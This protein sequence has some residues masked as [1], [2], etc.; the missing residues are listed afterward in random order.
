MRF[1]AALL[2]IFVITLGGGALAGPKDYDGLWGGTYSCA[3]WNRPGTFTT[4]VSNGSFVNRVG[5]G[6]TGKIEGT[7]GP[8]GSA[9]VT[10][11]ISGSGNLNAT[12]TGRATATQLIATGNDTG[13]GRGFGNCT[14]RMVQAS[15]DPESLQGKAL[16]AERASRPPGY[17]DAAERSL[18]QLTSP[19]GTGLSE[20]TA[21]EAA[22][23]AVV[24]ASPPA[25]TLP[26]AAAPPV[27]APAV[28]ALP[29]APSAPTQAPTSPIAQ[30]ACVLQPP[31]RPAR[32]AAGLNNK[33]KLYVL[34]VG[35]SRYAESSLNLDFAA[36]DACDLARSL[37]GQQDGLYRQVELRMI[38]NEAANRE[39]ILD[40][41]DWIVKETTARD[42]AMVFL[43]GHGVND[44]AG[45]YFFLP[46]DANLDRLARSAL[47]QSDIRRSLLQV[48]GKALFFFDT[49]HSGQI[50]AG[51]RAVPP[52]VGRFAAALSAA[53]NS[54]I[55]FSAATGR[56][57][58]IEDARWGNGA[59][60]KAL[61]E[62]IAGRADYQKDDVI[63]LNE[64]ELY[65]SE[66]VKEL[67]G[68][69]QAPTTAKPS[70]TQDFPIAVVR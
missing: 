67:T 49:C 2:S 15:A 52:D 19:Y 41:L 66:R 26:P 22:P 23:P 62:G 24:A 68:G 55:V 9:R 58:A 14:L 56:Q 28:A 43:A 1:Y 8:E 12:F 16:A 31:S 6:S 46:H 57:F 51:R 40:G 50:M 18:R 4:S 44:A 64:L 17:L 32:P 45:E 27:V 36:K 21:S 34:S 38:Q 37:S 60:T 47:P 42:V 5:G 65:V 54:V 35:I 70:S 53:D 25:A 11:N 59:F 33:P 39:A 61:L 3:M 7:I 10:I 20:F 13:G 63:T 69:R 29:A 48:S 30:T